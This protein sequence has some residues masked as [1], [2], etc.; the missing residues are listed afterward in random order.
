[1]V[2]SLAAERSAALG[3]KRLNA[4][5]PFPVEKNGTVNSFSRVALPSFQKSPDKS[6]FL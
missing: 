4:L 6:R 5:N 3:G 1:M 2:T